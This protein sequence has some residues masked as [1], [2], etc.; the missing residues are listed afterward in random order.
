MRSGRA[1]LAFGSTGHDPLAELMGLREV[2]TGHRMTMGFRLLHGEVVHD[3]LGAGDPTGREAL[4]AA[5]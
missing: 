3:Y 5:G 1:E 4:V 2:A